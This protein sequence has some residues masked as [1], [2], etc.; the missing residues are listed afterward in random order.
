MPSTPVLLELDLAAG[1]LEA[2]PGDPIAAFRARNTPVLAD[3]V[4][5]L[6]D[7]AKSDEVTGLIAHVG[8]EHLAFSQIH[9]L[10]AAVEEFAKSGKPTICWSEAFGESFDGTHGYHL[11]AYFDEIWVQPS[12]GVAL[13]GISAGGMFLREGLD[14][15]GLQPEVRARKEYKNAPDM[16]L[17]ES[18]GDAQREALQRLIDSLSEHLVA[19]VARR[20]GLAEADVVD[21][22]AAAPLT[23]EQAL[24]RRLVDHL[25]YRDQVYTALRRRIAGKGHETTPEADLPEVELRFVHRWSPPKGEVAREKLRTEVGR[26]AAKALRRTKPNVVAVVGVDGGIVLG[27][28]GGS[29]LGGSNTGSDSVCAALRQAAEAEDVAAVVV[30]IDSPGGSYVASDAIHREILRLRENG[31]PVVASMASVAASGGYFVA[32]GANEIFALP[33]T[34]TGSIGVFAGKVVV[35]KALAKAGVAREHVETGPQATMWSPDRPFNE[36]ELVRLDAWLD[37]VYAD[38]TEKAADGR[39]MAVTALE[40][41]ARGRVWTGADALERGLVD[42]LG[43]FEDAVARATT[44][45]GLKRDA[46]S[47]RRYPHA[48]M[49]AKLRPPQHSDAVAASLATRTLPGSIAAAVLGLRPDATAGLLATG[50]ERL[51]AELSASL[52]LTTGA[53]QLPPGLLSR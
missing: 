53:L 12:G 6:R 18:M 4:E 36:D 9:E 44:L 32:M 15:V 33:G 25:G 8:A 27:R 40:P 50:P 31:T 10:G 30:R 37:E 34:I 51:L 46:V 11:A 43:G 29:P 38:F 41:L 21:A 28:G 3:L 52:G 47:V 39:D 48:S 42:Q 14:K 5:R 23:S 22:I 13:V 19:T 45:A 16:F 1:L 20:R 2:P 7:A 26:V 24:D 17:R 49:L 35:T